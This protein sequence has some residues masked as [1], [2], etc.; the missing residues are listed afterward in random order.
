MKKLFILLAV[1][2]SNNLFAQSS[3]QVPVSLEQMQIE[4]LQAIIDD[5]KAILEDTRKKLEGQRWQT[6]AIAI[7]V[8]LL[9]GCGLVFSYLQFKQD[10]ASAI[11]IKMGEGGF[12][13]NTSVI[14]IVILFMSFWFFQTYIDRVYALE[15]I[16]FKQFDF[17]KLGQPSNQ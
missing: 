4:Y 2:F 17:S 15:L 12:S 8:Y 5:Q 16:E 14:G 9:V 6:A 3:D 13:I 10:G 7:M 1:L 11:E